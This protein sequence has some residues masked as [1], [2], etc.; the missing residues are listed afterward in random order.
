FDRN[1]EALGKVLEQARAN[2]ST[3]RDPTL[4]K[5]GYLYI[6]AMDSARADREGWEPIK[7]E[8]PELEAITS[9]RELGRMFARL[10]QRD[11]AAAVHAR[12]VMRL[13]TALAESSMTL[14]AQRDPHA[15]YHKM[16]VADLGRLAPS[17]DW[18]AYF[19]EVGVPSL[20]KPGAKLDVSQ[21]GF[22]MQ[23]DHLI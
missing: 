18:P 16:T 11:I 8:L 4:R 19:T 22:V 2:A 20:A 7:A 10:E 17:V 3:T 13:E 5:L 14:V 1:Q 21:P 12:G 23:L 9:R 15:I 6:T